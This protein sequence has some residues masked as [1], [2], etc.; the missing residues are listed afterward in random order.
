MSDRISQVIES[1]P[2]RFIAK[3]LGVPTPTPLRRYE[4]AQPVLDGPVLVGGPDGGRLLETVADFLKS[5]EGQTF[6]F[7]GGPHLK[8]LV[9]GSKQWSAPESD[10]SEEKDSFYALVFD[11]T[12]IKDS[13]GLRAA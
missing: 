1:P 3:Q 10:S 8:K 12:G 7:G 4:V 2:G 13:D 11:A 6:T 5:V 9:K